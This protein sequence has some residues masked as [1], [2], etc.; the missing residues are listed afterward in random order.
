MAIV[1]HSK[2]NKYQISAAS[3]EPSSWIPRSLSAFDSACKDNKQAASSDSRAV[4]LSRCLFMAIGL[5]VALPAAWGAGAGGAGEG[6]SYPG[7]S[8]TSGGSL[9]DGGQGGNSGTAGAAGGNGVNGAGNGIVGGSG[10]AVSSATTGSSASGGAGA[11][12]E[13]ISSSGSLAAGRLI[14]GGGGGG[15]GYQDLSNTVGVTVY[16]SGDFTGGAGGSAA[17]ISGSSLTYSNQGDIVGGGGGA[18]G[19]NSFYLPAGAT[20]ATV[21]S[22][23]GGDGGDAVQVTGNDVTLNNAGSIS[24]GGGGGGGTAYV[25]AGGGVASADNSN[26]G[27]GGSA[28]SITG[29]SAVL[30]NG[31]SIKGGNGGAGGASYAS[32][33]NYSQGNANGGAGGSAVELGGGGASLNNSGSIVGGNGGAADGYGTSQQPGAGGVGVLISSDDNSVINSGTISGGL[34][35][36]SSSRANAVTINGS[37]NVLELQ[38][39]YGFT[40]N[41]VVASGSGNTLRLG[42]TANASFDVGNLVASA[43]GSYSGTT[44]Y[45]GFSSYQ[46]TGSSTWTLT[47]SSTLGGTWTVNGGTLVAAG[48]MA[49]TAFLVNNSGVLS[50]TGSTGNV[51]IDSGG[52]LYADTLGSGLVINGNLSLNNGA[53]YQVKLDSSGSSGHTTVNGN[54][55]I[56]SGVTLKLITVAGTYNAG[57]NYTIATYTG[58]QTGSFATIDHSFAFVTP[59][60]SYSGGTVSVSLNANP[61]TSNSSTSSGAGNTTSTPST[62][63]TNSAFNSSGFASSASSTNQVAL[64]NALTRIYNRGGNA[65]TGVLITATTSEARSALAA[66]SGD[67]AGS[68]P[69]LAQA[70]VNTSQGMI[71]QRL[72]ASTLSATGSA[73]TVDADPWI[74]ASVTQSR[75]ETAPSGSSGYRSRSTSLSFGHDEA[76]THSWLAGFAFSVNSDHLDYSDVAS[77]QRSTGGQAAL[78]ARYQPEHESVFFKG[79]ASAGWWSNRLIR[80]LSLGTLSGSTRGTFSVKTAALYAE[81]G[82]QLDTGKLAVEPYVGLGATRT[83]RQAFNE[84]TQSGSDDFALAYGAIKSSEYVSQVGAR[85]RQIADAANPG[86]LQWNAEVA[87]RHRFNSD[88]DAVNV[89][90]VNASGESFSVISGGTARN[91]LRLGVGATYPLSDTSNLF[92]QAQFH[93]GAASRSC[94]VT[95]GWRWWW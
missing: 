83:Y 77:N 39:G 90:F 35:G 5:G 65:L 56:G 37:N 10:G 33:V 44:R 61:A 23:S 29:S 2:M 6:S 3:K 50:G 13:S 41:V 49:N 34:S 92:S 60:V 67:V 94:G 42:G 46:K 89:A 66:M 59:T 85:L 52:T 93:F 36:N 8:G 9:G 84:S 72:S 18:G 82:V 7:G 15:G 31:G 11:T 14:V 20:S 88:A 16:Q 28:V 74:S 19:H 54:F 47:G 1:F 12:A 25:F 78:Y 43:P 55:A 80:N 70:N 68:A 75:Q 26:G 95:A 48:T 4:M 21:G 17:F 81:T 27:V 76:I 30:N 87:W 73:V 45:Y 71:I 63:N 69:S 86:A 62:L 57:T 22:S 38:S 58:T 53:I 40:G 24:G 32:A 79:I 91:L 64:A 51:I